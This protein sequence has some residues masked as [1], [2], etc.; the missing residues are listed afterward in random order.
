MSQE[1]RK[2][3]RINTLYEIVDDLDYYQLLKSQTNCTQNSIAPAFQKQSKALHPDNA[4]SE[5]KDKANYIFTA[6]NEAF[7]ILKDPQTRLEYD[8]LLNNGVIRVEDT[9]LRSGAERS[10]ANDPTKAAQTEQSKKY[11]LMG[12]ADMDAER[13]E[14]AIMNIK[15][16]LQFERNNEVFQEWLEKAKQAAQEAPQKEKNPFKIRL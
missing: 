1:L 4:P 5:L 16:A 13:F 11:W 9:A 6:I 14:S 10:S 2:T 15:F 12:L 8:G 7:R 3:V